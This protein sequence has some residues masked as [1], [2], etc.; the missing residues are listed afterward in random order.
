MEMLA[1]QGNEIAWNESRDIGLCC[2]LCVRI[3]VLSLK[4]SSVRTPMKRCHLLWN[5][6]NWFPLL[7]ISVCRLNLTHSYIVYFIARHEFPFRVNAQSMLYSFTWNE[8]DF[9]LQSEGVEQIRRPHVCITIL[10]IRD[11][12]LRMLYYSRSCRLSMNDPC[13]PHPSLAVVYI[14]KRKDAKA[15]FYALPQNSGIKTT[16]STCEG[17]KTSVVRLSKGTRLTRPLR[18][19]PFVAVSE[20]KQ[21]RI[22]NDL[23]QMPPMSYRN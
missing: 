13:M 14:V 22:V 9:P 21:H 19:D 1:I 20:K 2:L 8:T 15:H 17:E 3:T 10:L 5:A 11:M 6:S 16:H 23:N 12:I 7:T 18:S 4:W